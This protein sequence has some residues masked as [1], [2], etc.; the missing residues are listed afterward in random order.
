M[1]KNLILDTNAP[2]NPRET[3]FEDMKNILESVYHGR[4]IAF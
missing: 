1:A 4:P 3:S 2:T